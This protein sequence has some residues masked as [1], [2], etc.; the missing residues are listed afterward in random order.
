MQVF[1][2]DKCRVCLR[3]AKQQCFFFLS[4]LCLRVLL[5]A[6]GLWVPNEISFVG[7]DLVDGYES[8]STNAE[9]YRNQAVLILGKGNAAFETAQNLLGKAAVVHMISTNAVR[10]AWQTHYVGDVRYCFSATL[11]FPYSMHREWTLYQAVV[12]QIW[13]CYGCVMGERAMFCSLQNANRPPGRKC[14]STRLATRTALCI[15]IE[16]NLSPCQPM[17]QNRHLVRATVDAGK[18][19]T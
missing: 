8:M 17:S 12:D 9:D 11:T 10:L 13:V 4:S 19:T 5:V 1:R 16:H 14:S 15:S 7:S 6:T 18:N 2:E 3:L